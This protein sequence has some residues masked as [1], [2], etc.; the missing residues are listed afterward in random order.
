MPS[1]LTIYESPFTSPDGVQGVIGGPH[2]VITEIDKIHHNNQNCQHA[3]ISNHC[4]LYQI[5][6]KLDPDIYLLSIKHSKD[7]KKRDGNT[8]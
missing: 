5:G 3:Y 1:G 4:K 6:Y 2:S 7:V 8:S